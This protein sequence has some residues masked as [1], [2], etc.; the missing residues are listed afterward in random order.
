MS[1]VLASAPM[2]GGGEMSTGEAVAGQQDTRGLQAGLAG[3][4]RALSGGLRLSRDSS[5]GFNA[6]NPQWSCLQSGPCTWPWS[7][8]A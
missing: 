4:S 5:D 6:T 2:V 7:L 1:A 8:G 3:G